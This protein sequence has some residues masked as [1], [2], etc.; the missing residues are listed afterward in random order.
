MW[1]V[2][3]KDSRFHPVVVIPNLKNS[4]SVAKVIL[5][6]VIHLKLTRKDTLKEKLFAEFNLAC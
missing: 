5:T 4:L 1:I 2:Q 3:N 6:V